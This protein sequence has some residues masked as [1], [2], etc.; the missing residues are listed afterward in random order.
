MPRCC[1]APASRSGVSCARGSRRAPRLLAQRGGRIGTQD[2]LSFYF[3]SP[4]TEPGRSPEHDLFVQS[5]KL[6]NTL[7]SLMGYEP[8]CPPGT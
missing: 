1:E 4:M 8:G 2:W 3:K 7:R 5:M 6:K